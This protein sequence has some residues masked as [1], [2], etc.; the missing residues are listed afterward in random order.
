MFAGMLLQ[1]PGMTKITV[2]E[3]TLK[4]L[5]KLLRVSVEQNWLCSCIELGLSDGMM[6]GFRKT[7]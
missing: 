7:R 3:M 1:T 5:Q 4:A 6:A 2:V